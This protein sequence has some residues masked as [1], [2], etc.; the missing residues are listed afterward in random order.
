MSN[1]PWISPARV[2]KMLVHDKS[3]NSSDFGYATFWNDDKRP[4][5]KTAMLAR[6][7]LQPQEPTAIPDL[8]P[9]LWP[10]TA[11]A[12]KLVTAPRVPYKSSAFESVFEDYDKRVT[13]KQDLLAVVLTM[14]FSH[15][16]S[17]TDILG[18]VFMYCQEHLALKRQLTSLISVHNPADGLSSRPPHAHCVVL[19]RRHRPSGWAEINPAFRISDA[20]RQFESEWAQFRET[21]GPRFQ[22]TD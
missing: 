2:S 10:V 22:D 20:P 17:P 1:S 6:A 4:D 16:W 15:S 13:E 14:H 18:L 5:H 8:P 3:V 12:E 9:G 21:W 19:I 11:A 7:K